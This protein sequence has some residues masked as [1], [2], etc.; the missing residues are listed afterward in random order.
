VNGAPRG[1]RSV[2]E[3]RSDYADGAHMRPRLLEVVNPLGHG[4]TRR[5]SATRP[6]RMT[7]VWKPIVPNIHLMM[8]ALASAILPSSRSSVCRRSA[9]TE[10]ILPSSRCSAPASLP[11]SRCSAPTTSDL[12]AGSL[13]TA[14]AIASAAPFACSG[15][16]FA[17]LARHVPASR[18][19]MA[20]LSCRLHHRACGP[21]S[22]VVA[23]LIPST[24]LVLPSLKM[25]R[26]AAILA[27]GHMYHTGDGRHC[28]YNCS[29][30]VK[31]SHLSDPS[32]RAVSVS[33]ANRSGNGPS[34]TCST[35]NGEVSGSLTRPVSSP[36]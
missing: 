26:S 5:S 23:C 32:D 21:S 18:C 12:V 36:L 16:N 35:S 10:S 27:I 29:N 6:P 1:T 17:F 2:I 4:R 22:C 7:I 9:L 8:S 11:S 24:L 33:D 14:S 20:R 31:R 15:V 19:R 25:V 13:C 30:G 28:R 3:G 34:S